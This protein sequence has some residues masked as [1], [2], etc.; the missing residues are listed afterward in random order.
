MLPMSGI[1]LQRTLR[2]ERSFSTRWGVL[3]NPASL[4]QCVLLDSSGGL[5]CCHGE[6]LCYLL[7]TG[8]RLFT[9]LPLR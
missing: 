5:V 6:E 4:R 1:V 9:G 8:P 7:S 2:S 3:G